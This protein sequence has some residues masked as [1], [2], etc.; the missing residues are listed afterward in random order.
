[1][2]YAERKFESTIVN[3]QTGTIL[4]W[5][6]TIDKQKLSKIQRL[7]IT[8]RGDSD[9]LELGYGEQ[10]KCPWRLL[11][12]RLKQISLNAPTVEWAADFVPDSEIFAEIH[13]GFWL[14]ALYLYGLWLLW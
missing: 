13:Y 8:C 1:M 2:F 4:R 10:E 9:D 14:Y 5:L 11:I 12:S 7:I 3:R 6:K